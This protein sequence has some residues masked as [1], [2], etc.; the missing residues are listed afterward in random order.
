[1]AKSPA[2]SGTGLICLWSAW[3]RTQNTLA[4]TKQ[5]FGINFFS[6]ASC[7][8]F[9]INIGIANKNTISAAIKP[10][11]AIFVTSFSSELLE[12]C[13]SFELSLFY[14][15]G[16]LFKTKKLTFNS[17]IMTI[18]LSHINRFC[19]SKSVIFGIFSSLSIFHH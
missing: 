11:H 1:M 12:E 4:D 13:S 19:F 6:G 8:Y 15:S 2:P 10:I 16:L 17:N 9:S 3:E 7:S 18:S 14:Q 5:I